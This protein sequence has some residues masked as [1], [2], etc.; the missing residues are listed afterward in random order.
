MRLLH[1]SNEPTGFTVKEIFDF[2][3]EEYGWAYEK[4]RKEIM[5]ACIGLQTFILLLIERGSVKWE[6]D[7]LAIHLIHRKVKENP[8]H[9]KRT[10]EMILERMKGSDNERG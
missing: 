10:S 2:S 7:S 1:D 5:Q 8:V 9:A 3:F 6:D 4:G